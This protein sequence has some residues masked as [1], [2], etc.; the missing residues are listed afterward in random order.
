MAARPPADGEGVDPA[1]LS[2]VT[3]AMVRAALEEMERPHVVIA[4]DLVT[5]A[6]AISGPYAD[7]LQAAV[8]VEQER[9]FD[10][11]IEDTERS[12]A[13]LPLLEPFRPAPTSEG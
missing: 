3:D 9:R 11:T 2:L 7:G 1:V 4:R 5:G 6:Q 13:V 8:A 10:A 12:Y